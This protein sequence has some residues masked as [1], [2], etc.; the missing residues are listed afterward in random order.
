MMNIMV[1]WQIFG[2]FMYA[3]LLINQNALSFG[4][5]AGMDEVSVA[6]S[7]TLFNLG[8]IIMGVYFAWFYTYKVSREKQRIRVEMAALAAQEAEHAAEGH[9]LRLPQVIQDFT[10]VSEKGTGQGCRL[11]FASHWAQGCRR[12]FALGTASDPPSP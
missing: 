9:A 2:V 12:R 6:T 11:R 3:G 4:V 7:L 5:L 1:Q 10:P 8:A